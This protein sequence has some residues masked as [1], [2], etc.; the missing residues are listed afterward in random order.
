M[1]ASSIEGGQLRYFVVEGF[2]GEP[3]GPWRALVGGLSADV[4]G[5]GDTERRVLGNFVNGRDLS[6]PLLNAHHARYRTF[7]AVRQ[8]LDHAS[9]ARPL[10]IL[11]HRLDLSDEASLQLLSF[12]SPFLADMRVFVA[13]TVDAGDEAS[14]ARIKGSFP[15]ASVNAVASPGGEQAETSPFKLTLPTVEALPVAS[16]ASSDTA[17]A[18]Q[19]ADAAT[20]AKSIGAA[21]FVARYLSRCLELAADADQQWDILIE[22]IKSHAENNRSEDAERYLA[23]WL[24]HDKTGRLDPGP[25]SEIAL[26]FCDAGLSRTQLSP[27]LERLA[28]SSD[29]IAWARGELLEAPEIAS[30]ASGRVTQGRWLGANQKATRIARELGTEE[31]FARTLYVYDWW[32]KADLDAMLTA[33]EGWQSLSGRSRALSVAAETLMYRYGG[34]AR[35]CELLEEQ[36]RMHRQTGWIEEQAK[37]LVRLSMALLANGELDR[38]DE[39]RVKARETVWRLGPEYLIYEHAGTKSGGDL[40]PE[41]SMESNFA[42][43]RE[44]DWLA[45]AEHWAMA[46]AMHEGAGSPVHIVEAAM[47]AQA[48]ARL[49]RFDDARVYLDELMA[50]LPLLQPRDWAFNGAVGRATHAIW[51]MLDVKYASAFLAFTEALLADGVGDWTN[52]S[53]ELSAARMA[54]L[55]GKPELATEYF[56]KARQGLNEDQAPQRG[57]VDFDE[58]I[59]LRLAGDT[60]SE[61]RQALLASAIDCFTANRMTGWHER[62]EREARI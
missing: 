10:A 23:L 28:G 35:A 56:S 6:L 57:I 52:T 51:D 20:W 5:L 45:V 41:I 8:L 38:A 7:D 54:A 21:E 2:P 29:G 19:W 33:S 34:F 22:L 4:A 32:S 3:F 18:G 9:K 58:A 24:E 39:T 61:R 49:G 50:I 13:A 14:L 11:F 55:L 48:Y 44:G 59:A 42:W 62:A 17:S 37:S 31:D 26:A 27:L 40:Y 43:Y 60:G 15:R 16:D 47:T 1:F 25:L 12:L 36:A 53:L 46:V 30:I